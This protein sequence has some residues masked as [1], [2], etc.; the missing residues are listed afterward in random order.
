MNNF[1][2]R[3]KYKNIDE[4]AEKGDYMAVKM[5]LLNGSQFTLQTVRLAAFNHHFDIVDH[6]LH[7]EMFM[8]RTNVDEPCI[9]EML[10]NID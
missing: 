3:K 8:R 7:I 6:F 1:D 10:E 4:A 2:V 5:F 9:F